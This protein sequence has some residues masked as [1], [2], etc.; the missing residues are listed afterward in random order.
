[1]VYMLTCIVLM[2]YVMCRMVTTLNDKFNNLDDKRILRPGALVTI[3]TCGAVILLLSP[4]L[5]TLSTDSLSS[6]TS[7]VL[8][9]AGLA[10]GLIIT[11]VYGWSFVCKRA[12]V[13]GIISISGAILAFIFA[14]SLLFVSS[15]STGVL[16]LDLV[17]QII[18]IDDTQCEGGMIVVNIDLND[19][20]QPA[21]WR[22]PHGFVL[23]GMTNKPFLPWPT[24]ST[25]KSLKLSEAITDLIENAEDNTEKDN[26]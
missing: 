12:I 21:E 11:G 4:S 2:I 17:S 10:G 19:K 18:K 8:Q 7:L 22:C 9:W 14:N 15:P 5:V 13:P 1:M 24:Y 20:K 3:V 26:F 6:L 23:L 16:N 25:G